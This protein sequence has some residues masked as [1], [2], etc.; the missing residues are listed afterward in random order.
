MVLC[1]KLF[2]ETQK[3]MGMMVCFLFKPPLS[4]E[5]TGFK[6]TLILSP[7]LNCAFNQ[8]NYIL[9]NVSEVSSL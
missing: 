5:S 8:F 2:P 1:S 7:Y 9:K 4:F 6:L 3:G